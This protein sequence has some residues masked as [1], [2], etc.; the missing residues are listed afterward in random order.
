MAIYK[1][2]IPLV[3]SI[4]DWVTALR[5]STSPGRSGKLWSCVVLIAGFGGSVALC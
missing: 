4:R 2:C 5:R 3:Q 1:T